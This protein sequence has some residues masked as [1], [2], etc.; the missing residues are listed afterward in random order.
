MTQPRAARPTV[1]FIDEYC[2]EYKNLFPEVR[3]FEALKQ[4]HV[5]IISDLKRKTLPEIAKIIGL[6]NCQ[7]LHHFLT[8]SPW[9]ASALRE[10]RLELILRALNGKEIIIVID[11]TGD[12]KKGKKTDYVSRQYIGN[13]GKVE[14]GIVAVTAYGI[15]EGMTVVLSFEVYKPKTR[16]KKGESYRSKPQ[17]AAQMLR[18]LKNKGFKFSQVLADSLY[19]ESASNFI[20]CLEELELEYVVAIRSNHGVWMPTHQRIRYNKWRKFDRIF[21]DGKKQV[22]YIREVIYGK[23]LKQQYWEITTNPETLPKNETWNVMTKIPN[24]KYHQVGNLYGLR[25]WVEYGLKQTKNE[26]GWADFRL[27]HYTDIEKWWEIVCSAYLMVS[28]HSI[29]LSTL[30]KPLNHIS[31]STTGLGLLL[32]E[33]HHW[34]F[35]LGWKNLLNNLRLIIQ[36]FFASNLM[37]FWLKILPIPHLELGLSRLM[38][39]MNR[40]PGAI[41][42][43]P[44]KTDFHFSSA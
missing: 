43:A 32:A 39:F 2:Q 10:R 23:R 33:H 31:I 28:L 4:L 16:L 14:Q 19:G 24:L 11:E 7:S 22:R 6:G 26:L 18:E 3:S 17:I 34:D 1:K 13:L 41:P 44:G 8:D 36:P 15:V 40:F 20:D 42:K 5:G 38:A 21:A 35:N 30:K 37:K 29:A 25:N 27:T 12:R 9:E